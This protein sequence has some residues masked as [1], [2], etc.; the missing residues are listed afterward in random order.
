MEQKLAKASQDYTAELKSQSDS[1]TVLEK[2][3][4]TA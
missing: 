3:N 2:D 1:R 4:L